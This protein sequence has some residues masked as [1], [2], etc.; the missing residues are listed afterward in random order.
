MLLTS[1]LVGLLIGH[2]SYQDTS[3][4]KPAERKN[5]AFYRKKISFTE[6]NYS[7]LYLRTDEEQAISSDDK[8]ASV[9]IIPQSSVKQQ[10]DKHVYNNSQIKEAMGYRIML[11]SGT[12]SEIATKTRL[13]FIELYPNQMLINNYIRPNYQ[14]KVG[15]F[16]TKLEAENFLNSIKNRFPYS[17]IIPEKVKIR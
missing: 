1:I 11:Y 4:L 10:L 14:I 9:T 12:S 7:N 5:V 15:N 8:P 2:G 16:R 6:P 3:K 17:F 13:D